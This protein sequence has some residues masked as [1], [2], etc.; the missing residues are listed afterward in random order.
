MQPSLGIEGLHLRRGQ[1]V[2][3]HRQAFAR[4]ILR[5][6]LSVVSATDQRWLVIGIGTG[7]YQLRI[8]GLEIV[9][10]PE[11]VDLLRFQ[12]LDHVFTGAVALH[13]DVNLQ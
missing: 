4:Q 6:V 10:G 12:R 1:V 8:F 13:L 3:D 5:D 9:G 7:Q 11:K 2:I